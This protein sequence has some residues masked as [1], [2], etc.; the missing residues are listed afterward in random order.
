MSGSWRA[1]AV[2]ALLAAVM[3]LTVACSSRSPGTG[4]D[5]ATPA[6]PPP[7]GATAAPPDTGPPPVYV[8]VGASETTGIGAEV[9]LRDAWPRVLFRSAMPENTIFVNMGIP[10]ATV[11]QALRDELPRA[12]EQ[13]PTIATVWL[14]VNDILAGVPPAQFERELGML[15]NGL[16]RGG[17]TRVL[18]ANTPPLDRLPAYLAC[19]PS[20]PPSAPPCRYDEGLPPPEVVDQLVDEYNAAT[21]RVVDREGAHLVDLHAVGMAARAAGIEQALIS[22]DG[23]HPNS[24]GYQRVATAFAEV[25][26]RTGPL[27]GSG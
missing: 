7:D 25:L 10:G 2:L 3:L 16:R 1:G 5:Q 19:R 20:P 6:Q 8:A 17:A 4:G 11:A 27:N 24:G 14:N 12:L 22:N 15:V 26:R 21:V 18:V 13:K 23:F 9:P